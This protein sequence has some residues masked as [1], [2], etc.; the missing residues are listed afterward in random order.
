MTTLHNKTYIQDN[1]RS[2]NRCA[3][4][5]SAEQIFAITTDCSKKVCSEFWHFFFLMPVAQFVDTFLQYPVCC[6]CLQ[7]TWKK[8]FCCR[9][10]QLKM[11]SVNAA[12]LWARHHTTPNSSAFIFSYC[13]YVILLH[14]GVDQVDWGLIRRTLSSVSALTLLVGSFDP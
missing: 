11:Q 14:G 5:G 10:E 13:I 6:C 1:S 8:W 3:I 9:A 7:I 4:F 2:T 12:S